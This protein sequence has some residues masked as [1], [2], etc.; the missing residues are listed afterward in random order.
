MKI[1]PR[2]LISQETE[3]NIRPSFVCVLANT[4]LAVNFTIE[5]S[6]LPCNSH[7]NSW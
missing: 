4:R 6:F 7:P 1:N 3:H 5:I 2:Y